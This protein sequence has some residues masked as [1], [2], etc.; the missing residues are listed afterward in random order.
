MTRLTAERVTGVVGRPARVPSMVVI[1]ATLALPTRAARR[2]YRQEFLAELH[3]MERSRQTRYA[4]G[5]LSRAWALRVAL[6]QPRQLTKEGAMRRKPAGCRLNIHH[7][8]KMRS[9]EDGSSYRV[10][11]RCGKEPTDPPSGPNYGYAPGM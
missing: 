4:L 9:T 1:M 5:V 2:R 3:G 8:W 10:C 11:V 6:D 7:E